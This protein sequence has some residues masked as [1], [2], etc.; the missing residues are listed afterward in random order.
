MEK[1]IV[2]AGSKDF[3]D[4]ELFCLVADLYLSDISNEYE[5][6]IIS[7]HC[8]DTYFMAEKYASSRGLG[9]EIYT[10]NFASY[11]KA[12]NDLRN[13]QK[14]NVKFPRI[15]EFP[16]TLPLFFELPLSFC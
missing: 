12:A 3:K 11:G 4:Y 14:Q 15:C 10:A 9:L 1:R 6:T 2:I 5:K 16:R 13:R 7:G 8:S